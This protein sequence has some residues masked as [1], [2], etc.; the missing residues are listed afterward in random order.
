MGK[1]DKRTKKEKFSRVLL[2]IQDLVKE[3]KSGR[4]TRCLM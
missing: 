4:S 2:V 1:G 3:L